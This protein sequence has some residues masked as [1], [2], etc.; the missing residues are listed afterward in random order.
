[1]PRPRIDF[2][3]WQPQIRLWIEEGLS[4]DEVRQRLQEATGLL[5][6]QSTLARQLAIWNINTNQKIDKSLLLRI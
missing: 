6:S 5:C 3:T 1:M 4:H 2:D